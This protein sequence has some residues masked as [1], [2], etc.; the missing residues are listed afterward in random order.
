MIK[1]LGEQIQIIFVRVRDST[2]VASC[3]TTQKQNK[4][5]YQ[6]FPPYFNKDRYFLYLI[7][8]LAS[9]TGH[10]LFSHYYKSNTFLSDWQ[11]GSNLMMTM[12]IYKKWNS[13]QE[14]FFSEILNCIYYNKSHLLNW[15]INGSK[16]W[17]LKE[18]DFVMLMQT[19][20]NSQKRNSLVATWINCF[21]SQMWTHLLSQKLPTQ[22]DWSL[23]IYLHIIS[24]W[25]ACMKWGYGKVHYSAPASGPSQS[26]FV[27]VPIFCLSF[28]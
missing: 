17:C 28:G 16:Y 26:E 12:W 4:T 11:W 19:I 27:Y 3:I 14:P 20:K 6:G 2:N 5:K 25:A 21:L 8:I 13:I 18:P 15:K 7:E 10:L 23:F 22:C 9:Y 24:N 1:R